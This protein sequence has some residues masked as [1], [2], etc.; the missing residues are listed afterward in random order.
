MKG[1][2]TEKVYKV[3]KKGIRNLAQENK[4]TSYPSRMKS[5]I[6][7]RIYNNQSALDNVMQKKKEAILEKEKFELEQSKS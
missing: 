7:T 5:G 1:I 2:G 6:N 4:H 3:F